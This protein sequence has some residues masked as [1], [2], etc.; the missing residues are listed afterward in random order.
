MDSWTIPLKAIGIKSRFPENPIIHGASQRFK[1]HVAAGEPKTL[2]TV[3]I[4]APEP[5]DHVGD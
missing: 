4:H 3:L 2:L 5:V 1:K